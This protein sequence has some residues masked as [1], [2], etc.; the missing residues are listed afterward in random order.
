MQTRRRRE[1]G[2]GDN[3]AG[4][5]EGRDR[6]MRI[7]VDPEAKEFIARKGG[8]VTVRVRRLDPCCGGGALPVASAGAP[9][10]TDG[11]EEYL[12]D[13]IRVFLPAGATAG[14]EG[15][16]IRLDTFLFL[17]DLAVDGLLP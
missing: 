16:R 17:R 5:G 4:D 12:V 2:S 7:T 9:A 15:V 14:P 6:A 13:G 10:S 3:R 8:A 1:K 11:Y